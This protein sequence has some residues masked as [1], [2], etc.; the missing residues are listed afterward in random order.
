MPKILP[1]NVG[2]VLKLTVLYFIG[3]SRKAVWVKFL[4]IFITFDHFLL[5]IYK[6][7][8]L[9]IHCFEFA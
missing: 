7:I 3:I 1:L 8:D 5:E 4:E 6:I 9:Q 2:F